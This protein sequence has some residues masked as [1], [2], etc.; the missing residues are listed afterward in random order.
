MCVYMAP[1]PSVPSG[2]RSMCPYG[3]QKKQK[4]AEGGRRM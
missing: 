1:S 4:E 2:V 3:V